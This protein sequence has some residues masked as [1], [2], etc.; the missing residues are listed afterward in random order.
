MTTRSHTSGSNHLD[1]TLPQN[2]VDVAQL[3]RRPDWFLEL[4]PHL[5]EAEVSEHCGERWTHSKT[6]CQ[7]WG[8]NPG[9]IRWNGAKVPV[10]VP[11]V[12]NTET[13][14]E[15]PLKTYQCLHQAE[16]GHAQQLTRSVLFGLS[17]RKYGQV[18]AHLAQSFG[19]SGA[20]TGRVFIRETTAALETFLNRRFDEMAFAALLLDGKTLRE[21][22]ILLAAGLTVEGK[23]VILGFLEAKTESHACVMALLQDLLERGFQPAASLLVLLDGAKGLHKGVR[24]VF[25]D[26]ALIQR[27][28]WHKRENVV[29]NL[30][31][32]DHSENVKH[33]MEA[34]YAAST[35]AEAKKRL[36]RLAS[37]LE[38]SCPAAAASLN[39]GLEETLTLHKLHIP[40]QLRDRLRTTNIIES[41]NSR[42]A[43]TTRR[44]TR[45]T[46]SDQ[47]QRWIAAACLEIEQRSLKP[48][49]QDWQWETLIRAL[50]RHQKTKKQT[51]G[52]SLRSPPNPN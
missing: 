11:R 8:T 51:T 33:Q 45:W 16:P 4:V 29:S 50:K 22:Q 10:A 32:R 31:D 48:I 36:T 24:E 18:A 38:A 37:D 12:R 20:T 15:V 27:C 34:A 28:Q 23:N 41:I 17:Q 7:R 47:R 3:L 46:N 52:R 1:S 26:Q 35:Y 21:D 9:S 13:N 6:K 44:V 42:L 39:E 19:L 30:T 43:H 40:R 25:G 2:A 49:P 14:Q 5:F